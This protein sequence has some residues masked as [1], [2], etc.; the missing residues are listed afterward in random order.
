MNPIG[1]G[2]TADIFAFENSRVVKLYK[3][4]FPLDA[5]HE[6]Y[7]ASQLVFA[8]G[9]NIPEPYEM[10]SREGRTGIV[11]QKVDGETLLS[12]MKK[13]HSRMEEHAAA[14]AELHYSVHRHKAGGLPPHRHQKLALKRN[15]EAAS[16]LTSEE[17]TYIIDGLE[18][19]PTGDQ[20]CH[21][22]FHPDNII[23]GSENWMI[24]WMTAM[25]GHPN[26]DAART[27][28]LMRFGTMPEGTPNHV[29]EQFSRLRTQ[30]ANDYLKSYMELSNQTMEDIENWLL[31]VAA[32]RLADWL[33]GEE[34]IQLVAEI[35]RRLE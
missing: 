33:P 18:A 21:G 29:V 17:K 32:A 28:L 8:L 24:D 4:G 20:L 19:L 9:I 7:T 2:R 1:Y 11:F 25:I 10:I 15:I 13:E 16:Q 35:R 12:V 5:I 22:D 6:E 14:M 23:V 3:A 26:G 31:P 34:R 30:L 27:L